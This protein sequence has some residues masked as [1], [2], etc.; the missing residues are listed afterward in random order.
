MHAN[1]APPKILGYIDNCNNFP[2][3][4]ECHQSRVDAFRIENTVNVT[5]EYFAVGDTS[6]EWSRNN[7]PLSS[8][9]SNICNYTMTNT[10]NGM[11]H[12]SVSVWHCLTIASLIKVNNLCIC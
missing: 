1:T 9:S 8:N 6:V 7:V 10:S 4:N 12:K 3:Y 11:Y 2:E 5:V